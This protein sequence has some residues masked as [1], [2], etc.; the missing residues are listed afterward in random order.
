MPQAAIEINAVEASDE[1]LPIDTL[2]QL[3][4]NDV[5]DETTYLWEIVSQPPGAP[6]VP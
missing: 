5:G 3:S 1:N 6:G 2:V 4:N